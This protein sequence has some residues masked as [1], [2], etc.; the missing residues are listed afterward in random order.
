[1]NKSE[2]YMKMTIEVNIKHEPKPTNSRTAH[3]TSSI[4][5]NDYAH[6]KIMRIHSSCEYFKFTS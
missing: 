2:F 4:C 1:M 5:E 3:S 6:D